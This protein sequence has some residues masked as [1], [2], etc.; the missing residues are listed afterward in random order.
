MKAN[1]VTH[2]HRHESKFQLACSGWRRLL[3]AMGVDGCVNV[4]A[5]GRRMFLP[6]AELGHDRVLAVRARFESLRSLRFEVV[7]CG[8][9]G[10]CCRW[11]CWAPSGMGLRG[12]S[13]TMPRRVPQ[14]GQSATRVCHRCGERCWSTTWSQ[15][16]TSRHCLVVSGV[17]FLLAVNRSARSRRRWLSGGGGGQQSAQCGV[18]EPD[19]IQHTGRQVG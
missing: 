6:V 13:W 9:L 19:M 4:A 3:A 18:R 10:G 7:G 5:G 11:V 1:A 14:V 15:V 2:S 12:C 16:R 17:L 8:C